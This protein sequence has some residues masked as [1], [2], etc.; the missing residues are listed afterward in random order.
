MQIQ[1]RVEI[2]GNVSAWLSYAG[3]ALIKVA[4]SA[5]PTVHHA[6]QELPSY[7]HLRYMQSLYFLNGIYYQVHWLQ[8]WKL[9]E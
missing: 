4:E 8:S 7:H 2:T 5:G 9:F 1:Y 3:G 6:I